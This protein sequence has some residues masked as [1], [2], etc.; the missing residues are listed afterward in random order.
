MLFWYS[1][2]K[3]SVKL[4]LESLYF[5]MNVRI[6]LKIVIFLSVFSI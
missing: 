4:G 1:C 5:F 2:G 3:K 6:A